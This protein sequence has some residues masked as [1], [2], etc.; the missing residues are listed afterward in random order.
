ML[1]SR[2][3]LDFRRKTGGPFTKPCHLASLLTAFMLTSQDS[4]NPMQ[5]TRI[6]DRKPQEIRL[7]QVPRGLQTGVTP[8]S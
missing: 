4:E 8:I 3:S 5:L 7:G 1:S 6:L 2:I